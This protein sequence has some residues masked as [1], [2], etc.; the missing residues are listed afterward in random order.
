MH[1]LSS[2]MRPSAP[3]LSIGPLPPRPLANA[4]AAHQQILTAASQ[5]AE[6]VFRGA[7]ES[8]ASWNGL[9]VGLLDL[10]ITVV[11]SLL[12]SYCKLQTSSAFFIAELG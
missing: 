5:A 3:A 2:A 9:V 7:C 10:L 8:A 12:G 4:A 6:A 1:S 11:N